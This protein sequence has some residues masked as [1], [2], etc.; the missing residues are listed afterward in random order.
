[1][2]KT[3]ANRLRSRQAEM[4]FQDCVSVTLVLRRRDVKIDNCR[5]EDVSEFLFERL[6]ARLGPVAAA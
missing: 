1:V 2:T 6:R 5:S 3:E 4:S